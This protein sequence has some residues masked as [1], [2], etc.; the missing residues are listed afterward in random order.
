MSVT[1]SSR[2]RGSR[3]RFR[4]LALANW[5]GIVR[6]RQTFIFV[7]LFPFAFIGLFMLIDTVIAGGEHRIGVSE[8]AT[9]DGIQ[10][11]PTLVEADGID[12]VPPPDV[13]S[14]DGLGGLDAIVVIDGSTVRVTTAG[15][16]APGDAV[17]NELADAGISSDRVAVTGPDG[18]PAFDP[19]RFGLPAVLILAFASLALFGTAIP[20]ISL[21]AR[22]TLR[23]LG[24]TPL[25]RATFLL[26]QA[27]ARLLIALVQLA[28]MATIAGVTGFLEP[29][30][31][32]TLLA[33]SVV[34]L[35]MLFSLGYLAAGLLHNEELATTTLGMLMPLVLMFSGVLL[36]LSLMPDAIASAARFSPFTYLGDA[37]RI[38][39]VGSEGSYSRLTSYTVMAATAVVV[40]AIASRIFE[41]DQGE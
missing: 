17:A 6:D 15:N 5:R 41:W 29:S 10:I 40:T 19:F 32:L 22:G 13:G 14:G 35:A 25:S 36:P 12:V 27:P 39:L 1:T 7:L 33:T 24:M 16:A 3:Q 26:A 38:D 9:V 18:E 20:L 2:R 23:H 8:D 11:A 30:A 28:V 31:I 21:R 37:L 4:Q 34:G